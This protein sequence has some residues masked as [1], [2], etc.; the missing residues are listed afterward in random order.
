M[1]DELSE[2]E[3]QTRR[4]FSKALAHLASSVLKTAPL[5]GRPLDGL[6][7]NELVELE[8][9]AGRFGRAADLA[10]RRL[11]RLLILKDDPDFDGTVRDLFNRCE[12]LGYI[13]STPRWMKMREDRNKVVH[14]YEEIELEKLYAWLLEYS[15]D[16][17]NFAG[18]I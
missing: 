14:E 13:D 15:M 2:L 17:N 5:V 16:L 4:K 1:S 11:M 9:L 7:E 3:Q 8:G 18:R 10:T 12:K 6:S